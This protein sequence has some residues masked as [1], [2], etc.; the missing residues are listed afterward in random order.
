MIRS[1]LPA[2][3]VIAAAACGS[4]KPA[5]AAPADDG[6]GEAGAAVT[7]EVQKFHDALA[8]RWHAEHGAPRMK[9]TCDAVPELMADADAI[10]QASP[11]AGSD[12]AAWHANVSALSESIVGLKTSCDAGDASAFETAFGKVHESFHRLIGEPA[13]MAGGGS[14]ASPR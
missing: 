11:P 9:S 14:A 3:L 13:G 12:G 5:P 7:P 10:G 8:P 6:K 1:I 4:S 2:L